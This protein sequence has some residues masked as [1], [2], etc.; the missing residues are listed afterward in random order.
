[1]RKTNK[2]A[3]VN[4]TSEP[5]LYLFNQGKHYNLYKMLG[6]HKERRGGKKG[7]RF[8][9]WAPEASAVS[10]VCDKNG[11]DK[12]KN[13]MEL[14]ENHGVWETFIEGITEG[15]VYKYLITT[16]NGQELYKADPMA[17]ASQLRPE[18]ASVTADLSYEWNDEDWL[19]KREKTEP[20][21]KPINIYEMHF[22]SWKTHEDGSFLTYREMADE[23]V[24]YVKK[25]GWTHIE[26]MPLAEYPFDG[27][28][29]YQVTGYYSATSRFGSGEDLKY[30]IDKC[31]KA[32]IGV[33]MDW[34]PAH[35]PRDSHGLARFDGSCL[36]EHPDSRRG[37]HKEW[38]TLVFDW[39][40]TE[41]HSFLISNA[42]FW[43]EEYHFDGLRVDAVSS[44]LYLDYNRGWDWLPNKFGG[45]ENLEAI[46]F[47]QSLNKAVFERFPN[48][49]MIAEESTAWGGV[50]KPTYEGGLGFNFKWNMGWMNDILRYMAMDP[51]FRGS[52]HN[53]ITFSM[54][55]AYSENYILPLSH[56]E[57]VH[58]KKSLIDKMYGDYEQ[59]FKSL[60]LLYSFMS[61]HPGKKMLFMGGE[62]GQFI[63]W[64]FAEGL[65]WLLLDYDRHAQMKDFTKD[66]NKFYS[67]HKSFYENDSD[68]DG[69]KWINAGDSEHSTI[70]FMRISRSRREKIIAV[71][72]FAAKDHEEYYI[73]VPA[74]GEY[75]VIFTT[76][77][78]KY[79]GEGKI[80][81]PFKAEKGKTGDFDYYIKADLP[82]LS[83]MYLKKSAKSRKA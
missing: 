55:Y 51:Y 28:W 36:Y 63:E 2:E 49:L 77:D 19:L 20:Y 76:D 31:H 72:N 8:A 11:W 42:I 35:F 1:M 25:Q 17:F 82:A 34:V 71:L 40:K 32:G 73:G 61:A 83:S 64:R 48:I 52:N 23:L 5:L 27:S 13:P 59:K 9:V 47:L 57:V 80:K 26:L 7:Y 3:K 66:L 68:W 69:F 6:A 60:R 56:D 15:E 53:L 22:G 50:T 30:F 75:E 46:E 16:R 74:P 10:V 67:S 41:I 58:G 24:P 78:I 79:G 21:N 18:T 44:M 54:M 39:T 65:D 12:T 14:Y 38:G 37:E 70:S 62:F 4:Y 45:K 81:G 43:L 33:I 29:G